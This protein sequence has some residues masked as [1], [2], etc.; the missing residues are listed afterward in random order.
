MAIHTESRELF[1]YEGFTLD[2]TRGCLRSGERELE[3]RPKSFE[4]LRFLVQNAD[5]LVSKDELMEA[6]WPGVFVTED[7]LSRCI[8]D[9]RIA[10]GD[11]QHRI[12]KTVPRRGY[13]FGVSVSSREEASLPASAPQLLDGASVAV[14]PFANLSGDRSQE[15]LSDGITEDIINGLSYFSDLSV[16]ASNS[17]FA[18][19]GRAIDVREVGRQLGVRYIVEGSVRKMSDRIRIPAQLID[20]QS[21]VRQ[22]AERFDR[23]LGDVFAVQDEIAQSI[24]RIV[25]AHLGNAEGERVSRKAPSSWTAYDLTMQGDQALRAY[26]Q[27]WVSDHLYEARRLFAEAH[28]VDPGNAR[29]CAMLGHTYVRAYADPR[30]Q[31]SGDPDILKH[32]YELVNQAVGLDPNLPLARAQLGWAFFWMHRPDSAVSEYEKAFAVNPN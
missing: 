2:V 20:T 7:S 16:I 9:V 27:S 30:V 29:I 19:K 13:L 1:R 8:S 11:A 17:S 5:R 15:Y 23:A 26:E 24:V 3:L 4:V 14:L 31:D 32:G 6:L 22:W 18:Y 10:L 21:G 28:K 12:I 25:V